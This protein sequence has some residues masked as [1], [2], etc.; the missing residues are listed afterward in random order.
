MNVNE[1]LSYAFSILNQL[2]VMPVIQALVV[3]SV[4]MTALRYIRDR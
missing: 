4:A 3:L 1:V 2:G